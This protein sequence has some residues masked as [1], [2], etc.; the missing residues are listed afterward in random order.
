[1]TLYYQVV[2]FF[3]ESMML[4]NCFP[5]N[6]DPSSLRWSGPRAQEFDE[7]SDAFQQLVG[8]LL[9]EMFG[10][11]VS[12]APTSGR[13]GSIDSFI[14]FI[15]GPALVG[16]DWPQII[17]CKDHDDQKPRVQ[18]NIEQGWSKVE[19]KLRRQAAAGW[20]G[21][22]QPW[23]RAVSYVYCVSSVLPNQQS[24]DDLR[25]K[26]KAFFDG[27]PAAQRP[28]LQQVR[29]LDWSDIR[30]LLDKST[31]LAGRWLAPESL[32]LLTHAQYCSS[33]HDFRRYLLSANLPFVP[34]PV[35]DP[36]HPV[37][38]FKVLQQSIGTKGLLLQG[39]GGVGKTRTCLEVANLADTAGWQVVHILPADPLVSVEQ[40]CQLL[41]AGAPP[42]LISFD[43]LDQMPQLDLAAV[44]RQLLGRAQE[45]GVKV[46]LLANVRPA[47]LVQRSVERDQ[48]FQPV[49]LSPSTQHRRSITRSVLRQLCPGALKQLGNEKVSE[50]CGPRPIVAL[51][52][53]TE[54]ESMAK[55]GPLSLD[56][57]RLRPGD[58]VSWL[59]R[60]LEADQLLAVIPA[61]DPFSFTQTSPQLL[62]SALT[63]GLAPLEASVMLEAMSAIAIQHKLPPPDR[64]QKVLLDMGWL[65]P[66][67]SNLV[68]PHDVVADELLF[69]AL[70]PAPGCWSDIAFTALMSLVMLRPRL[71][72][73][74][75]LAL[76][77]LAGIPDVQGVQQLKDS[78]AN[79]LNHH[80]SALGDVLQQADPDE[81][82][83]AL[84]ALLGASDWQVPSQQA[85]PQLIAPWLNMHA[86]KLAARHFLYR[87]L[88]AQSVEIS[89]DLLDACRRWL[90][91]HGASKDACF[92]LG[93]LLSHN[94]LV[95]TQALEV[96]G[97]ARAWLAVYG[98]DRDAQF[99]L[100]PLLSYREL[101]GR[102]A[103]G[104]IAHART[105]LVAQGRERDAQF[106]LGPLL[107][108][109]GLNGENA[110]VVF[111]IACLWLR[112]YAKE[113][114]AGFVLHPLLAHDEL[115]GLIA[116]EVIGKAYA[117]LAE[118]GRTLDAR[119]VLRSLLT[120]NKV[121][122]ADSLQVL[123]TTRSWLL[124]HG[125]ARE[126]GLVIET[127]LSCDELSGAEASE[128]VT[129]ACWW[130]LEHG[131]ER[132]AG[133][134]M[135][136]LLS[137]D[138][139]S[140]AEASE[141][142]THACQWLLEHGKERGASFV[143]AAL[144][145]RC[146]SNASQ[147]PEVLAGTQVWLA[148]YG[149]ERQ[150]NWLLEHLLEC[151]E[152]MNR[153]AASVI[154]TALGWLEAHGS[155]V[156]ADFLTKRLMKCV[157]S[158]EQRAALI[159][160]V[161]TRLELQI[162]TAD[163]SYLLRSLLDTQELTE[164]D[165]ARV[166]TLAES[167][168]RSFGLNEKADFVLNRLLYRHDATDKFWCGIA[169]LARQWL[170]HHENSEGNDNTFAGM[171]QRLHVLAPPDQQWLRSQVEIRIPKLYR[172]LPSSKRLLR[173]MNDVGWSQELQLP[174]KDEGIIEPALVDRLYRAVNKGEPALS[175]EELEQ[176]LFAME[177][178]CRTNRPAPASRPLAGLLVLWHETKGV[179]WERLL[180]VAVGISRHERLKSNQR[181]GLI[182]AVWG[183]VDR[184]HW[185][186]EKAAPVLEELGW[187][188]N[189][190]GDT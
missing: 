15:A 137:R 167:W 35:D 47:A 185:P 12:V 67:G 32:S 22:F 71:L 40:L 3:R 160:I 152:L 9:R 183:M 115:D 151:D 129:H 77:R 158:D 140:G 142:I 154:T 171:L 56:F 178:C 41:Q 53:A 149:L 187:Q 153:E 114:D 45:L 39:V 64:V 91:C 10:D 100:G 69:H 89:L 130:L 184:G 186:Q 11:G 104:V 75:V 177:C 144:L 159:K 23:Q 106:V 108:H 6:F 78:I 138:V 122:G 65:E 105:W 49:N 29:V 90:K 118:H 120:G 150:A 111:E 117:W 123:A 132:E 126:A 76:E 139:L 107:S 30:H 50:L 175:A 180:A 181:M 37:Q 96:V 20:P 145:S 27:L 73:R 157:M 59:K 7:R 52:I 43:Y 19:E 83:Y 97:V 57:S 119:F 18:Q 136:P 79:W 148:K 125:M 2:T 163:A 72:A 116:S 155:E 176:L 94:E 165:A 85:W 17:E 172:E 82:A 44:R 84:G 21:H 74:C 170:E 70:W 173:A 101:C 131:K 62:A 5:N 99:V 38:L 121:R 146:E 61:P 164:N 66:I 182:N 86:D 13:D 166:F 161:I 88:R 1:M 188:R 102:D 156:G 4:V 42:L 26:I 36:A 95:G 174:Y 134:V 190:S 16:L 34:P 169:L 141:V 31:R 81:A 58:L 28:P 48:L 46:A 133:F 147:L 92:V 55:A 24:R 25:G 54:L 60:R 93:P 143:L 109:E 128:V 179:Q 14:E 98:Q 127:L 168:L 124:E 110:S 189:T 162:S 8:D 103:L 51:L 80:A 87:G 135:A 112:E 113:R 33:L 63:V 68:T